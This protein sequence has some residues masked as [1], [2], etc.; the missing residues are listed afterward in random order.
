MQSPNHIKA[1][2]QMNTQDSQSHKGSSFSE[3]ISLSKA[4]S[5]AKKNLQQATTNSQM[6]ANRLALL[7]HEQEK[8]I[9][10]I[11]ETRKKTFDLYQVKKKNEEWKNLVIFFTS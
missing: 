8:M 5:K 10:K 3:N 9:C 2:S 7:Q 6:L 1:A 11:N 4:M